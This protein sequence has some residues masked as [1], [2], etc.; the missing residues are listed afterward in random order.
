M[1]QTQIAAPVART[2]QA[3]IESIASQ[4][5]ALGI[6][7]QEIAALEDRWAGML[8]TKTLDEVHALADS[9]TRAK[10]GAEIAQSRLDALNGELRRF[11]A[12]QER[13]ALDAEF[14]PLSAIDA[15]EREVVK[16]YEEHAKL[17]AEALARLREL[18]GR[19]HAISVRIHQLNGEWI[20]AD[21]PSYRGGLAQG[22]KLPSAD[23]G[24]DYWPVSPQVAMFEAQARAAS[25]AAALAEY[26][27]SE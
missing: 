1:K 9:V 25:L 7:E 13:A 27:E 3:I 6:A 20:S 14:A 4:S 21:S 19:L 24:A 10:L 16:N 22:V 18:Q 11:Y 12:A 17:I 23:G 15:Q 8:T 5:L 2:E 26:Q